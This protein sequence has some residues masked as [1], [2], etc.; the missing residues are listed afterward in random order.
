MATMQKITP[1]LWFDHQAEEAASFYVS[2]FEGSRIVTVS[3]Y[4]AGAPRPKGSAMVVEFELCGQRFQALNGGPVFKFT[5]AISLVVHCES[6]AE[7]D[8]LWS[9]LTANG[10][11]ESQCGWLKDRFGLSWQIVPIRFLELMQDPDPAKA[12]RVMAAM[13]KM[14]KFDVAELERAHAGA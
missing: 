6:Q 13:M 9:A 12:G 3:R 7:V 10:G 5:E 8:K 1:F 11:Q 2:L 4:G 14:K